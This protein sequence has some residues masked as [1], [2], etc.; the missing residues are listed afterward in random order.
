MKMMMHGFSLQP[1][2]LLLL[3]LITPGGISLV[4]DVLIKKI[5]FLRHLL[6]SY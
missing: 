5:L 4:T 1:Q 6:F 2:P 3:S